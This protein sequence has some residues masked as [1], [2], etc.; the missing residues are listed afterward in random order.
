MP[1]MIVEA[2]KLPT[3]ER[4]II[5]DRRRLIRDRERRVKM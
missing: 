1:S 2:A 5:V 3:I 4:M